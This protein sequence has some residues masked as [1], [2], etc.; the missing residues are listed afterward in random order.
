M[1]RVD[2]DSIE[3]RRGA[4]G[5]PHYLRALVILGLV[6]LL[7]T[8]L[9]TRAVPHPVGAART[10]GKYEGKAVTTAE[11]ALSA[12]ETSALIAR[13]YDEGNSFGPYAGQ[14]ATDAEA[15]VA[16]VAGTF[17]S[18]QPPDRRSDELQ[19][20]LDQLLSDASEHT[21][22]VRVA[23]RRSEPPDADLLHDLDADAERLHAFV[24]AHS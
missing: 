23:L 7:L 20:E 19:S 6:L 18:I 3:V 13:T 10:F 15:D 22:S 5:R 4:R 8:V 21:R 17:N 9:A 16:A 14:V 11:S 2:V 12:V 1:S 24:E